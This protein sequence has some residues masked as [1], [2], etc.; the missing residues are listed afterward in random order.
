MERLGNV[1]AIFNENLH[2]AKI[3]D[4]TNVLTLQLDVH[5]AFDSLLIYLDFI[6]SVSVFILI[7]SLA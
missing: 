4:L 1:S 5:E 6:G 7:T 2:G 3:H